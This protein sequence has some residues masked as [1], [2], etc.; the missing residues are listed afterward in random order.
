[1]NSKLTATFVAALLMLCAAAHGID[2]FKHQPNLQGAYNRLTGAL[3]KIERAKIAKA[4]A[5]LAD[6]TVHL[7]AAKTFLEQAAK[8]KGSYRNEA[9]ELI[10]KAQKELAENKL[11]NAS[12]HI[13]E[14]L[15][16]VTKAA[17]AGHN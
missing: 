7:S 8:N 13:K 9:I 5:E 10:E 15:K 12:G 4:R 2:I 16:Q 17:S 3:N 14:A 1:M 11:D 6:A